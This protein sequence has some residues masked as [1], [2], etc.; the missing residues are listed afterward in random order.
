MTFKVGDKVCIIP[1]CNMNGVRKMIDFN[2]KCV[3][4]AVT[5]QQWQKG[6]VMVN[7]KT[8]LGEFNYYFTMFELV[9]SPL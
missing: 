1:T 5:S 2:S 8:P 9:R 3:V 6:G 4:K 7:I